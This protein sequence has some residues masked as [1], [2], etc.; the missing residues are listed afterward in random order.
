[1]N[2]IK[3]KIVRAYRIP[4]MSSFIADD[5]KQ[6][7]KLNQVLQRLEK[8]K[9]EQY[10]LEAINIL[11]TLDNIFNMNLLFIVLYELIDIRFH[12]TINF[13]IDKLNNMQT[14]DYKKLQ[15]LADEE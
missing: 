8:Y 13:L 5:I 4:R 12:N 10:I 15:D 3:L 9:K 14:S 7:K 1:M 6:I 11:R 2:D